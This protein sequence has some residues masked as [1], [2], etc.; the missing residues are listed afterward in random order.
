MDRE[1]V[2]RVLKDHADE[3]HARGAAALYLFGSTARGEAGADSDVDLMMEIDGNRK[4]SL[5]DQAGLQNFLS[6]LLGAD[7][8]L[9]IRPSIHSLIRDRVEED[10]IKVL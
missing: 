2:I 3:I 5:L 1:T 10:A 4:F 6:D 7:A 8:D 9:S